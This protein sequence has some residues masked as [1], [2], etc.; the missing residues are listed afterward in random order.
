[1]SAD[2]SEMDKYQRYFFYLIIFS[3]VLRLFWITSTQLLVEEAY[4]WSYAQHP[5]FSYLDHP[6]MVAWIIKL[7]TGI[8]GINEFAVRIGSLAGW[9]GTAFF[10]FKLTNRL[11]PGAGR[12]ALL[13]LA[14]LPF[15][16]LESMVITP[17]QPL[18]VCW[19]AA[20]LYL[21]R[22]TVENKASSWYL[23]GIWI[24]L[25][26]LSK[27]SICLLA[28]ATLIYL[29]VTPSARHWFSRKEPYLCALIAAVIFTPVIYWNATHEWASFIF[30]GSRRMHS[31][32]HFSLPE[33]MALLIF[34]LMPYGLFNLT[35][36]FRKNTAVSYLPDADTRRFLQIF[37]LVPLLTF[38]A[39]SLSH[40]I[41]FNWI[42]TG[43]LATVPWLAIVIDDAQKN[44]KTKV[45][46]Y[47][48]INAGVLSL[49]Y[50][51]VIVMVSSGYPGYVH[52]N[53]LRTFFCWDDFT[54]KFHSLAQQ[55]ESDTGKIPVFTALDSYHINS[56]LSFYQAKLLSKHKISNSYETN[57]A[58]FFGIDSLMYRYWSKK[59]LSDRILILIA[60]QSDWLDNL[61]IRRLTSA[62]SPIKKIWSYSPGSRVKT[63]AFYYQIVRMHSAA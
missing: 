20:L 60:P 17:D 6:P 42:G 15:F 35:K 2:R 22:A 43:L 4:Y 63:Q 62:Q 52:K 1:M 54:S 34:F 57:G 50:L 32:F 27:Y 59:D 10:S 18:M 11:V 53:L 40:S 36:L 37:T 61:E 55:I 29:A 44:H 31:S 7:F 14:V 56:Q 13:L 38:A 49:F 8:F 39:F 47:W 45:L 3:L 51:T 5:D 12:Y 21:Y 16:F 25:G 46:Q 58:H 19:S 41:K 48:L 26:M 23:S 30:Q 28:P 33:L 9:F 24:G